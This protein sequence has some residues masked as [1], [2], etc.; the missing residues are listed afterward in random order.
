MNAV[1]D[2]RHGFRRGLGFAAG[3]LVPF[4]LL[5][6]GIL[7]ADSLF[8]F[9]PGDLIS[10]A[11]INNNF[12]ELR[13]DIDTVSTDLETARS[14]L[15]APVGSI[16][17]WHKHVQGGG[18]TIPGGW[19]E[20]NGGTVN[21][22][23][24]PIQGATIPNLNGAASYNSPGFGSAER[25]FLRGG[26]TSGAGEDDMFESHTHTYDSE[27]ESG[28]WGGTNDGARHVTENRIGGVSTGATGG[29]ET[30]PKNMSVVWIMRVK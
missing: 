22:P 23:D 24:S 1:S 10:A 13:G 6:S 2:Y 26:T 11:Q 9:S 25:L 17:A 20:C 19:V 29:S 4:V 16:V 14:N 3:L 21:D 5:L 28:G 27:S 7:L 8:Q 15:L 18:L 12:Q 30:R